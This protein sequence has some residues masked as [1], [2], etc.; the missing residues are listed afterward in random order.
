MFFSTFVKSDYCVYSRTAKLGLLTEVE[1]NCVSE[2]SWLDFLLQTYKCLVL[3]RALKAENQVKVTSNVYSG[4]ELVL[5]NWLNEQYEDNRSRIWHEGRAPPRWV[6][7]F[8]YD[9][10]DGLVLGSVFASYCPFITNH[11]RQMHPDP[12]SSEECLHNGHPVL[13]F[14]VFVFWYRFLVQKRKK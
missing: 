5:L 10:M 7:N 3:P 2:Q 4:A 12:T 11:L 9:L 6:V 13:S 1:F 14:Y 8:D